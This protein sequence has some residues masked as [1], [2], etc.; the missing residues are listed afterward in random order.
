MTRYYISKGMD[1]FVCL[2][3]LEKKHDYMLQKL[4]LENR[5]IKQLKIGNKIAEKMVKPKPET[6]EML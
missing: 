4:F 2:T 3:N 5:F 6:E 1:F